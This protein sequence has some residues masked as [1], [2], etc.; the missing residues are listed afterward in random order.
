[1]RRPV[2]ASL[3]AGLVFAAAPAAHAC[4]SSGYSY[5]GISSRET[6]SGVSASLTSLAAPAVQNGHVA[7]WVGVGG[8]ALGPNGSSEWIQV[9]YS[10]FPGLR[11]GSLYYEV[12]LPGSSPR[13]YEVSSNVHQGAKHRV[14]VLEVAHRHG[15][16]RVW[17]DGRA[18]SRAYRLPESHGAWRGIATAENW[19]GGTRACNRYSYRFDRISVARR[20]G[21]TWSRLSAV[22]RIQGGDNR[23]LLSSSSSF[24]ARTATLPRPE[25]PRVAATA[26]AP[27]PETAASPT[28]PK[29]ATPPAESSATA[30]DVAPAK[31]SPEDGTAGDPRVAP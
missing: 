11:V 15:W 17:V 20:A 30:V 14:A 8:P 24:V 21:G 2:L 5:A 18:V 4:G 22:Y 10:G 31:A 29:P 26:T 27:A 13:Y 19:G 28:A 16:W 7:G 1:M 9:G 3:A 6:V 25:E 23:L 12:A